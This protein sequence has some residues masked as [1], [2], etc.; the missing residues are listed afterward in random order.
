MRPLE[1]RLPSHAESAI[2]SFLRAHR[3]ESGARAYVLGL[4][5][6]ID[7][8]LTARLAVDAVGPDRVVGVLMPDPGFPAELRNEIEQHARTLRME[9]RTV[10]IGEAERAARAAL[11]EVA[12]PIAIGNLRARLRMALLY[13]FGR[14]RGALVLGT[15]NKSEILLGYFTKYGDGGADLLPL[16]DLYK[17]DVR[18]L[19]VR[20]RL[21]ESIRSRA[22]SAGFWAGQ[23]DEA[24]LGLPYATL[25]RILL[26]IEE[27][28]PPE[29]IAGVLEIEP[30]T[31]RSVADRVRRF[32][33]KRIPPPIPK[34]RLR[35]V[36]LDW[37]D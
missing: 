3:S 37:R 20:L 15:G 7:S 6:G 18:T 32:R 36:G 11:P 29:E 17:T 30:A 1:V 24:E 19:A 35:T 28:R 9:T 2:G 21:P 12:E 22:P 27:L 5:G 4:S 23:T 31:V 34:L 16:G 13:A 26:G 14:E 8:A 33:H 25:D 10:E